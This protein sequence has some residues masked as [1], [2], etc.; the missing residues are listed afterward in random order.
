MSVM[1]HDV[2]WHVTGRMGGCDVDLLG[3]VLN[4]VAAEDSGWGI[5]EGVTGATEAT[6]EVAMAATHVWRLW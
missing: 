2:L 6:S 4:S 1:P 3:R 5:G